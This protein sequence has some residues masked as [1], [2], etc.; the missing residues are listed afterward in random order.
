M[1]LNE[2]YVS[3]VKGYGLGS[4]AP[5]IDGIGTSTYVAAHNQI[6]AHARA[7]RL[8]QNEFAAQQ[9]GTHSQKMYHCIL[10]HLLHR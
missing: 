1:T 4:F 6:I 3:A 9:Q 5:G 7:Y 10:R 8:Y 2:P